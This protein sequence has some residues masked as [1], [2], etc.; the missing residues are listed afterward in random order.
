M[1][2]W[3]ILFLAVIVGVVANEPS[4]NN[5]SLPLGDVKSSTETRVLER[6]EFLLQTLVEK[7]KVL[8]DRVDSLLLAQNETNEM[9]KYANKSLEKMSEQLYSFSTST[10][11]R[12]VSL[13]HKL[14]RLPD[15]TGMNFMKPDPSMDISF[16]V[17]RDWTNNFGFGSNWIIFQRRFNGSV[18]FYRNWT[19]YKQ[20]FGDIHGEHWLGLD[21]LHMI[22]KS[23]R[24]ELLIVL[25]DFDGVIAYAHY[26]D[27]KIGDESEKYVIK[28]VG[29]YTGTAG[30]S[31]TY[32]KGEVFSTYDQDNDKFSA[33]CAEVWRGAWW[34]YMCFK[35]H[36]NG[37]Y[38]NGESNR[39]A[40]INWDTFRGLDYSLQST[41]MMVRPLVRDD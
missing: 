7:V 18:D 17:A 22:V 34:F 3:Y 33:N 4:L 24:H 38:L 28:T 13:E 23:Q 35:S 30:D 37:R 36:L 31:F 9:F 27:F 26:D 6:V 15:D 39:E 1:G 2:I 25:E 40:G 11:E 16:E 20:G 10:T 21:K 5:P 32:H 12:A 14:D 8:D 19:E 29:Q 41:K